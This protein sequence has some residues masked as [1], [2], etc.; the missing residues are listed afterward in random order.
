[1]NQNHKIGVVNKMSAMKDK[2]IE[3][4]NKAELH[5][6]KK[7]ERRLARRRERQRN[8]KC[9]NN[10]KYKFFKKC[11]DCDRPIYMH[12]DYIVRGNIWLEAGMGYDSGWLHRE[13]LE[14]RL[15]RQLRAEDF[16]AKFK[17]Y[18][19]SGVAEYVVSPDYLSSPEYFKG[20][21]LQKLT[22]GYHARD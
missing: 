16:L 14:R 2:L 21:G 5:Y 3:Q 18:T 7:V 19:P 8:K 10:M 4:Q 11:E 9:R 12:D 1:V 20:L 15:G 17:K 13:C 22:G 6:G